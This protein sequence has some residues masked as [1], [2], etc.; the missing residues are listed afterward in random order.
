MPSRDF[1]ERR[2]A[3]WRRLRSLPPGTPEFEE[4]LAQLSA[5]T[6]WDRAR[7]LAGLGLAGAEAPPA[8]EGS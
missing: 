2:N 6:G 5:L 3:L 4:T 1:L 7:V 8:G